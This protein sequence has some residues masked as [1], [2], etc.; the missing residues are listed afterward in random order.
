MPADS[1]A[2]RFPPT[3][4]P[5]PLRRAGHSPMQHWCWWNRNVANPIK[6]HGYVGKGRKAL[7]VLKHQ[8]RHR[9]APTLRAEKPPS[10]RDRMRTLPLSDALG[11]CILFLNPLLA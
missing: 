11:L 5:A 4:F 3:N 2:E 10:G 7:M 9:C 6:Q 8:A 1:M